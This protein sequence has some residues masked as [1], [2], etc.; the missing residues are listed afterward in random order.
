MYCQTTTVIAGQSVGAWVLDVVLGIVCIAVVSVGLG[1]TAPRW[2]ASWLQRDRGPLRWLLGEDPQ[3]YR[4]LGARWLRRFFPELGTVFGGVSKNIPPDFADAA[5]IHAYLVE[6]R[7]AEWVHWLSMLA[8]LP[9]PFFQPW[10]LAA[11]FLVISTVVNGAAEVILRYNK[12]R[13][14][15][16]LDAIGAPRFG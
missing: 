16:L 7:R 4:A 8:C 10:G 11:A 9:L 5:S 12:V 2:P 15:L 13:L 1:A 14:Y 6:V 3:R